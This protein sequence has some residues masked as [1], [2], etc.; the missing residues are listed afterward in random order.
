M[1]KQYWFR[2]VQGFSLATLAIVIA[3]LLAVASVLLLTAFG[4]FAGFILFTVVFAS[5][6]GTLYAKGTAD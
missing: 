4:D 6:V 2:F 1:D 5:V 3:T